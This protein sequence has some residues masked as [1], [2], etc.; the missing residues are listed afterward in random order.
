M[1]GRVARRLGFRRP[2]DRPSPVASAPGPPKQASRVDLISPREIVGAL[3]LGPDS[4]PVTL[5]LFVNEV[6]VD[7]VDVAPSGG[8]TAPFRF[9]TRDMWRYCGPNDRVTVRSDAIALPMPDGSLHYSPSTKSNQPLSKLEARLAAGEIVNSLGVL[10]TPKYLDHEWQS[11]VTSLYRDID[12]VV[13]EI[14]GYHPFLVY[15][16]LLGLVREGRPLGHDH[17]S[18]AAYLS[19]LT[20]PKEVVAEAGRLAL[21]LQERGFSIEARATCIHIADASREHRID[22]YHFFFNALGELRLAWGSVSET[23]FRVEQWH[24]LEKVEFAGATV[25][26]PRNREDLVAHFYGPNWRVPNPGFNWQ[27][28]RKARAKEAAFPSE[29]RPIINWQDYWLHNSFD[30]PS[31]LAR[32]VK[33]LNLALGLVV[34]LGCGDGRD[35]PSFVR[36]G[37][38][39]L[40]LDYTPA[41]IESARTRRIEQ[42]TFERCDF[43]APGEL[44]EQISSLPQPRPRTLFYARH[45]LDSVPESTESTLL[46]ELKQV[47]RPEDTVV[48]EFRTPDDDTLHYHDRLNCGRRTVDPGLV[49][50]RLADAGFE[51]TFD[52]SSSS[53][54]HAG[55]KPIFLHRIVATKT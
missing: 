9:R 55:S 53:W 41:A 4:A 48:F 6:E 34:D 13:Y 28:A 16:S 12:R 27:G 11:A 38:Y 5:R 46:A 51:T 21:A 7:H 45:L 20:D 17:D 26:A 44:R 24:G 14:T 37:A 23:P 2:A 52:V 54:E 15:G 50:E 25:F 8:T 35:A 1:A 40:G 18:D 31:S 39:V 33:G 36:S 32:F 47:A 3:E 22:L 43:S 42:A 29:L 49:R 19:A 30:T 10:S